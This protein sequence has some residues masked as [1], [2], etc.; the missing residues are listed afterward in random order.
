MNM[1]RKQ[2][3]LTLLFVLSLAFEASLAQENDSPFTIDKFDL[4]IADEDY[5]NLMAQREVAMTLQ[6]L[7]S[8]FRE[9]VPAKIVVNDEIY[10][11]EIR[12]KGDL[13]DH[14][15][16]EAEMSFRVSVLNDKT[17]NGIKRFSIQHPKRRLYLDEWVFNK[18]LN[19]HGLLNT[20]YDFVEFSLNGEDR[21]I[22]AIE[23]Y[24]DKFLLE[25]N[26][27]REGPI[28]R[29]DDDTFWKYRG[30]AGAS[31]ENVAAFKVKPLGAKKL[32][33]KEVLGNQYELASQLMYKF[34]R[35]DLATHQVFEV[36][37]LA[38][39]FVIAF[40]IFGSV[41]SL[42]TPNIRFYFNPIT[43][44]IEPIA[45]DCAGLKARKVLMGQ[46]YLRD[47]EEFFSDRKKH[48]QWQ[49]TFFHDPVFCKAYVEALKELGK[50][51]WM[52]KFWKSVES[53]FKPLSARFATEFPDYEF[54][55][56]RLFMNVTSIKENLNKL[57]QDLDNL[58]EDSKIEQF[59]EGLDWERHGLQAALG[60]YRPD[61]RELVLQ[62]GNLSSYDVQLQSLNVG[63]RLVLPF[64]GKSKLS[65][66]APYEFAEIQEIVVPLPKGYVW[67]P[68]DRSKIKISYNA[69]GNAKVETISVMPFPIL[70]EET[71]ANDFFRE[72]KDLNQLGWLTVDETD[73]TITVKKGKH[74]ISENTLL[75]AGYEWHINAKTELQLSNGASIF[76]YSPLFCH[77]SK[78]APVI[79]SNDNANPGAGI[80]VA[81]TDK[82]S[83]LRNVEFRELR[84]PNTGHW[85][86]TGAVTFYE[87]DVDAYDCKFLD[88]LSE[89]GLNVVRA[90]FLL[91]NCTFK[92]TFSDAFDADFCTGSVEDCSYINSGNDGIDVSGS[93]VK[94]KRVLLDGVQDK[95]LS[96]GER[97]LMQANDITVVNAFIALAAKDESKLFVD[98]AEISSSQFDMAAYQKKSE[99][100]PA[101]VRCKDYTID[102]PK[103]ALKIE[104]GS[105]VVLDGK[106]K[107]GKER[108]LYAQLYG[109]RDFSKLEK[110]IQENPTLERFEN[111]HKLYLKYGLEEDAARI[112]KLVNDLKA[113]K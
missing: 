112:L 71:F 81:Q 88:N 109:E 16:N 105:R 64:D 56:H 21:G 95:G 34:I 96:S 102:K 103:P 20:R 85:I 61:T 2:L 79:I 47:Y 38:K 45:F 54:N 58:Q 24:A 14:W 77:G 75:P 36:K 110:Y 43:S 91:K 72:H 12:L 51:E 1:L 69:V 3:I 93:Q 68:K 111:L 104:K 84:N 29:V 80:V 106:T 70:N 108:A 82:R 94:I 74:K 25:R 5:E 67:S 101:V 89:D 40:D 33:K 31:L 27:R 11:V 44:K 100:G 4:R 73:K 62:V 6:L 76:S 65:A 113:E 99:F 59:A 18:V 13:G 57:P 23:E 90:D 17:I 52:P 49:R 63:S 30:Q 53:E 55:R 15:K 78:D 26:F 7:T 35:R 48:P 60:A 46:P 97:S 41:H 42:T 37:K 9:T 83:E 32:L 50:E 10:D 8:Q 92:N 39:A 98:G 19:Y 22:Y 86:I 28:F 87:A 107:H 66:K